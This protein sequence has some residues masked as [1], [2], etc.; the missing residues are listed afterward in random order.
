MMQKIRDI[1]FIFIIFSFTFVSPFT[2][3][4]LGEIKAD[5]ILKY[6][7]KILFLYL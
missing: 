7:E 2:Y 1:F 6:Y 4:V 3:S 5:M